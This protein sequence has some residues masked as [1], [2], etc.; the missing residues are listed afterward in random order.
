MFAI[1]T[2]LGIDPFTGGN[3]D[4]NNNNQNEQVE[5]EAT[6]DQLRRDFRINSFVFIT[7]IENMKCTIYSNSFFQTIS[8]VL[9]G[10]FLILLLNDNCKASF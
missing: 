10:V 8:L 5:E 7:F 2:S 4:N 6:Y 1:S 3:E 9:V